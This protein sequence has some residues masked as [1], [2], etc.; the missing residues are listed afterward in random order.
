VDEAISGHTTT[1]VPFRVFEYSS[2][3]DFQ[4]GYRIHDRIG[5]VL[6]LIPHLFAAANLRP[7]GQ[8][9]FIMHWRTAGKVIIPDAFRLT[10]Y[11]A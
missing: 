3:C 2:A 10:N 5:T 7:T 9:G 1:G 4:H 8:R 6:E 11:S